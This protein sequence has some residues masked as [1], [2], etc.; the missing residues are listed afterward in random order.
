MTLP[1]PLPSPSSTL[2]SS[3][4]SLARRQ[5]QQQQQQEQ[6][7]RHDSSN[8]DSQADNDNDND[9]DGPP[10]KTDPVELRERLE[11][12]FDRLSLSLLAVEQQQ[13]QQQ[14]LSITRQAGMM[15][16]MMIPWEVQFEMLVQ[17]YD[18]VSCIPQA[19]LMVAASDD[20]PT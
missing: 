3:D 2:R 15:G 8:E 10:K 12:F 13:Q 4:S 17:Q 9:N 6:Q 7:Q 11:E 14:Q 19:L 20:D 5:R 18:T 1:L 16:G